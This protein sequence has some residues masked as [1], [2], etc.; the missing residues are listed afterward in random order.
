MKR[1]LLYR[2]EFRV[3]HDDSLRTSYLV[4][5]DRRLS[6]FEELYGLP[7]G[8]FF[9]VMYDDVPFRAE[10]EAMAEKAGVV[11][12]QIVEG[13]NL[14]DA[15]VDA[16][17]AE[18]MVDAPKQLAEM[19]DPPCA[20]ADHDLAI[21][22][23]KHRQAVARVMAAE[24][25]VIGQLRLRTMLFGTAP[26]PSPSPPVIISEPEPE[27]PEIREIQLDEDFETYA[28]SSQVV[29]RAI[30]AT[31]AARSSEL[32]QRLPAG[33]RRQLNRM[34]PAAYVIRGETIEPRTDLCAAMAD[35]QAVG[36]KGAEAVVVDWDGEWP[37]VVRRYGTDGR[38]VYKVES[39]LKRHGVAQ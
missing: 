23:R 9:S 21:L 31:T 10:V 6:F 15:V 29:E 12:G 38:T 2:S 24:Q 5:N 17:L 28:P 27:R 32:P 37:V 13:Q 7:E 14:R 26:A 39:A 3:R 35:A 16:L 11:V 4:C 33:A 22:E 20:W 19:A 1:I 25:L 18:A 8:A 36:R 34:P 30:E